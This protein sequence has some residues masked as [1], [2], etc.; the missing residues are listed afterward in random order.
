MSYIHNINAIK[1]SPTS[2]VIGSHS[3]EITLSDSFGASSKKYKFLLLVKKDEKKTII[4]KYD[5]NHS[6]ISKNDEKQSII[7]KQAN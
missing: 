6:I 5:E 1:I 2:T 7:S 4:P 3:F